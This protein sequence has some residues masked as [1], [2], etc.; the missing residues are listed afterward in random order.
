MGKAV[1]LPER[2]LEIC[3]SSINMGVCTARDPGIDE[4]ARKRTQNI[5]GK[6][7]GVTSERVK[8]PAIH[9]HMS[10]GL[11]PAVLQ[12]RMDLTNVLSV[13]PWQNRKGL[14]D[15]FE[16]PF[17]LMQIINGGEYEAKKLI[18]RDYKI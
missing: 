10:A 5:V 6:I 13:S 9:F 14:I 11:K 7:A 16:R 15:G 3:K 17:P 8:V 4:D 12:Y 1:R 2:F 18:S